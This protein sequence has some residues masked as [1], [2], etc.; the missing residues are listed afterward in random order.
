MIVRLIIQLIQFVSFFQ[1]ILIIVLNHLY[2]YSNR[3]EQKDT[4]L[5]DSFQDPPVVNTTG[6]S[7]STEQMETFIKILKVFVF[8]FVFIGILVFGVISKMSLLF[9]TSHIRKDVKV[10]Y[11][12]I[13][14]KSIE[15]RTSAHIKIKF[16]SFFT[17]IY[18]T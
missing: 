14:R 7:A 10:P 18:R 13:R 11:C 1:I 5:W 17:Q 4:K 12:D 2:F 3:A 6:S 9:M 15:E 8:I 16:F